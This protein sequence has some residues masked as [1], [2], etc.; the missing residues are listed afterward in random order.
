MKKIKYL[1]IAVIILGIIFITIPVF[2][3]NLWFDESYT[4]GIV[5]NSFADIW[6]IGGNDVHPILY[7]WI[8]H[9]IYLIFG[10]NLYAYRIMSVIPLVVLG[11]LGYTHIRKDFGEKEGILFSFFTSFLPINCIYAGE[12]RM[13]TWA[14]LFV[15]LMS[16]YAY[17]IYKNSSTKNWIIFAIFSLASAYTH[18]Y[19]LV[20]A[21]IVNLILFIYLLRQAIKQ[22]CYTKQLKG[23]TISAIVQIILYMPWI[24]CFLTQTSHV[25]KGYWILEPSLE[26]FKQIFIFQFVGNLDAKFISDIVALIF[27]G[28]M[29]AYVIYTAIKSKER[30]AGN[31]AITIYILVMLTA[32]IISM[33]MPILYARYFLVLTGLFIFFISFFIAK[34]RTEIIPILICIATLI[35]AGVVNTNVI[36][37]NYSETNTQ[38]LEYVKQDFEDGDIIVWGNEGSGFT[39]AMQLGN[40]MPT[41]FYDESYW[42]QEAAY[43]AFGKNMT[44]IK[45]LEPLDDYKGRIWIINSETYAIYNQFV[46]RYGSDIELIKQKMFEID[47]HA[48]K[49]S[50][51]LLDKMG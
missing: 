40:N 27:G 30:R 20:T 10:T 11:I 24:A 21:G 17:R 51:T 31:W 5:K 8:L 26:L 18:Y 3:N 15:T 46:Q 48:Y 42:N 41:Y 32:L 12:L 2:H 29:L 6:R 38:P 36:K 4:V 16:I 23:F 25:S 28:I 1:H 33:K 45:T 49:Y 13:Y 50:V 19:A 14:M 22:K 37:M 44:T 43:E 35:I 39:L 47:Y 7:Y 9:I 34:G